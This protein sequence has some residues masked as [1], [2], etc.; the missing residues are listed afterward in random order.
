MATT[1]RKAATAAAA[2]LFSGLL[3]APTADAA[4]PRSST[5]PRTAAGAPQ[6]R[7]AQ[8]TYGPFRIRAVHS[9]KCLD[10]AG[11]TSATGDGADVF[12]WTC[13]GA[14]QTNQQ[15]YLT[16]AGDGTYYIRAR[17]SGKCL[18]VA[19]GTSATGD[20]ADVFQ[21]TCL[22]AA[23]TNQRW[24]FNTEAVQN[25]KYTYYIRALHSGK[26]LDVE[27]GTSATGDG[28]NVFQWTCLST[29]QTNQRWYLEAVA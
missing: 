12:Q 27:G 13:L 20:G 10:V 29:A 22:G 3:F 16:D 25:G 18:D 28:A 1:I 8:S 23:Q 21:W 19:G 6:A 7:S 9:G 24:Y 17:H 2:L 11:G 14:A 26:C 5:V 4:P 15:W